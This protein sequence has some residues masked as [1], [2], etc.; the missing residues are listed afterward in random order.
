MVASVRPYRIIPWPVRLLNKSAL[1]KLSRPKFRAAFEAGAYR[2]IDEESNQIIKTYRTA[3]Q[4]VPASELEEM[5]IDMFC[6]M[7]DLSRDDAWVGGS[8]FDFGITSIELIAFK[9]RVRNKLALGMEI[10]IVMLMNNPTVR[11]MANVLRIMNQ[12]SRPYDPVVTLQS[13]G[14]KPSLVRA[15]G[16]R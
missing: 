16:H 7:F 4:E 11:G 14:G 9:Q 1:G 12:G 13:R 5:I 3:T 15:P 6:E 8:F 10:P 2:E